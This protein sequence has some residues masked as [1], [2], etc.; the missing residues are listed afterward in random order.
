MATAQT[1]HQI[2][3]GKC[4]FEITSFADLPDKKKN[5]AMFSQ[6]APASLNSN[7][8]AL[9]TNMYNDLVTALT[10]PAGTSRGKGAGKWQSVVKV[11]ELADVQ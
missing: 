11:V 2:A 1:P 5:Q 6:A 7:D 8:V 3:L 4:A 9:Y 10:M